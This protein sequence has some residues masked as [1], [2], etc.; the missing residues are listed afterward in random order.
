MEIGGSRLPVAFM[1]HNRNTTSFGENEP[2]VDIE[3]IY[4]DGDLIINIRC[5]DIGSVV[6]WQHVPPILR[7]RVS[8]IVLAVA[9]DSF[10]STLK[11][12]RK[13]NRNG[14]EYIQQTRGV[15]WYLDTMEPVM[16]VDLVCIVENHD[17]VWA[18]ITMD[19]LIVLKLLHLKNPELDSVCDSESRRDRLA[20]ISEIAWVFGCESAIVSWVRLCQYEYQAVIAAHLRDEW[21]T[22]DMAGAVQ[23]SFVWKDT[24]RF[25]QSTRECVIGLAW[26]DPASRSTRVKE[27][28]ILTLLQ[29]A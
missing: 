1:A 9:S 13:L 8:S 29:G 10:A 28:G 25:R 19:F 22:S 5:V 2:L 18:G 27:M 24:S 14:D 7:A 20:M 12:V 26:V 15:R 17:T 11:E 23:M 4:P 3:D 6:N 21:V 16:V